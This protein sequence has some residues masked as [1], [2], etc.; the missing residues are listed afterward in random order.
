MVGVE[1][2]PGLQGLHTVLGS[3]EPSLLFYGQ[4][5]QEVKRKK[6]GNVIFGPFK[7]SVMARTLK[8][9]FYP[10]KQLGKKKEQ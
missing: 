9:L 6:Q 10:W 8:W 3:T 7:T 1:E 2:G 5:R 4:P